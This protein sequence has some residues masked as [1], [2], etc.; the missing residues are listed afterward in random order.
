MGCT[1]ISKNVV[2]GFLTFRDA[3]PHETVWR[4]LHLS[5]CW[6]WLKSRILLLGFTSVS[7]NVVVGFMLIKLKF[8]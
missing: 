4:G 6:F 8:D 7:K 3:S 5:V 2:V 1:P